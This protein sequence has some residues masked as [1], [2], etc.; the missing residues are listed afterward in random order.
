MRRILLLIGGCAALALGGVGVALPFLPTTPFVL[1]AAGC[2]AV[3]SPR[4]YQKLAETKYFG[5]YIRN[6]KERTGISRRARVTGLVFL[7]LTLGVSAAVFCNTHVWIA[8][9]IVGVAVS[10]HILTIRPTHPRQRR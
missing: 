8:L 9:G 1:I 10:A 5:E 6:Y 3:S 7:W 4:L 2:F